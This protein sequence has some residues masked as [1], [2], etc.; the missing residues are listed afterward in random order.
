MR[1]MKRSK[2]ESL[3]DE[4]PKCGGRSYQGGHC[5][6]CGTYRPSKRRN[7]P[8][9]DTLDTSEF[10][11]RSFGTRLSDLPATESDFD[12]FLK[13]IEMK[14]RHSARTKA[15]RKTAAV[16]LDTNAGSEAA[17]LVQAVVEPY[18]S[19]NEG[20][21][22]RALVVPWRTIAQRLKRDWTQ[23]FKISSRVWEEMIAAA[24]DQDGYDE[25]TLTPRSGDHGR[26]VIAIKKGIGAIRIIN[27]VKAYKPGHLVRYDDV[28]ALAGVLLG[29]P[30][31]SKGIVTT[32]SDF[33]PKITSDP[34][35]APLMPYRLELMNGDKLRQWLSTL[36]K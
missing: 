15:G 27:S 29:D 32:T 11:K 1:V 6:R 10:M 9:V 3:A 5:L 17:L 24:F 33:A 23:A 31:A 28:R 7:T 12:D 35:L 21:L 16:S 8:D 18:G 4:C 20:Q 34:Y 22:V 26:D 14:S 19:T 30:K 36:S 2:D 25:V 13:H